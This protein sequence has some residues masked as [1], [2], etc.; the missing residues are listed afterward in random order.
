MLGSGLHILS[1]NQD[2]L[3]GRRGSDSRKEILA[4]S[5]E[6]EIVDFRLAAPCCRDARL[7]DAGEPGL[8]VGITSA[9][10]RREPQRSDFREMGIVKMRL[11]TVIVL[12]LQVFEQYEDVCHK[13]LPIGLV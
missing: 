7:A 5:Q 8:K 10:R 6:G 3:H 2:R 4:P 12:P 9:G 1:R 11:Q 13:P